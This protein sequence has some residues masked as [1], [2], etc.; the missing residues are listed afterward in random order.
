VFAARCASA[1][2]EKS[3]QVAALADEVEQARMR[4]ERR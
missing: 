3:A 4:S 1:W 2:F